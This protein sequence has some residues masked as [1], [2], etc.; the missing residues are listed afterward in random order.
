ML[1]EAYAGANQET[2][3]TFPLPLPKAFENYGLAHCLVAATP[4]I[5]P[6][7]ERVKRG[8]HDLAK[9][10]PAVPLN[11]SVIE[12]QLA[13]NLVEPLL[14]MMSRV[15][16]LEL[17]VARLEGTLEGNTSEERF[18]SFLRRLR[19]PR[20]AEALFSE[21]PVLKKEIGILLEKWATF[22]LEFLNHLCQDWQRLQHQ[23]FQ[24]DPGEII[25]V[26]GG[27]GDTHRG[28]RSVIILSFTSGERI[29]YKPRSLS[30]DNH[31]QQLLA[32]L[33]E[34]GA[35]PGFRLLQVLDRGDHG[36]SEFISAAPCS[37]QAELSQFYRR[38]GSYLALLYAIE[39]CDFHY[40]NLIAAGEHP[41]LVDLEALFHPP[42][43]NPTPQRADEIA[44]AALRRSVL[45]VGLLPVRVW[46][47]EEQ[48]GVDV[49]GLGNPAGQF[50][51]FEVPHWEKTDTDE[52]HMIRKRA[53]MSGADN[54]PTL[55]GAP[56]SAFDYVE[57]IAGGFEATYRLLLK[58]RMEF[59]AL[60]RSFA[61][62]EVR[63]IP[64]ATRTYGSL[65]Y[66]SFHPDM[67]R[68]SGTRES[69]FNNLQRAVTQFP[70][71]ERLVAAELADLLRGDIP[72]FTTRPDSCDLLTSSGQRIGGYFT[73]SGMSLVER[74]VSQLSEEDLQLQLW[75]VRA[76]I[77]TMNPRKE[78]RSLSE[79]RPRTLPQ[80]TA[81]SE[82]LIPAARQIGDRLLELSFAT[83]DGAAWIGLL[84]AN[85]REWFLSPLGPDLYD[86]L[87]G[88]ILFLAYLAK[89]TGEPRYSSLAR[90]ALK[91]LLS[92]V[93][94]GQIT[95]SIGAFSGR[96]GVIYLLT[97]LGAIWQDEWL[98]SDAEKLA[99]SL[100]DAIDADTNLDVIGGSA[101]CALALLALHKCRPSQET[102]NLAIAC[103]ERLLHM[104]QKQNRGIGWNCAPDALAP[105]A[106]F[107]HGNAGIGYA[108]LALYG[109]TH[110]QRF[111]DAALLA[112]EYERS[113]YSPQRRNW[114]DL[115]S[116]GSNEFMAAWCHGA[117]GIGLS[118]ICALRFCD[119][120][121]LSGEIEA[122]LKTAAESLAG[123]SALCHGSLGNADILLH[124]SE[125]LQCPQWRSHAAEIA[126]TAMKNARQSGWKCSNPLGVESP[127]L[128][129]GLTGIGYA[130]LR[131]A[132]PARIPSIL[133]LDP[134]VLS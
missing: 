90:A 87:P 115:R 46:A 94:D 105:L 15:L 61:P 75:I 104:A 52:M 28:G 83:G 1:A 88:V 130:L 129:T 33:K 80:P 49:S 9:H 77:A 32:W 25:K 85:E 14:S 92:Q 99:K 63:I 51:P 131:Q 65:L 36:W 82:E 50:T 39:A 110:D 73:E 67:L 44:G 18:A 95:E 13:V 114:P 30:A 7:R 125:I 48:S 11:P 89:V 43:G 102:L 93:K 35:E 123:D 132:E 72:L 97:H 12:Q 56:V 126:F 119:D 74:R 6:A 71:L 78:A 8:A 5:E 128:M 54:C 41:M 60:L 64:R 127:G 121:Q 42:I 101:G 58:R 62:D 37:T 107:A 98:F 69:F 38:Q 24:A 53:E 4:M 3:A 16:V 113:L 116:T 68:D 124:A 2:F 96:G 10:F 26:Q 122:S 27:A 133:A 40:E 23:F 17:N 20:I 100:V 106:G 55:A 79:E 45:G 70:E 59:L 91:T 81:S 112:F 22:S 47:T 31:F 86:G 21:Y 57:E 109:E 34:H 120:P 66:E 134:P 117:P 76:S 29:V 118:R 19:N 111:R 103:G 108:L 84:V